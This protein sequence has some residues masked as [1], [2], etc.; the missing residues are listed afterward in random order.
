MMTTLKV[1]PFFSFTIF[2]HFFQYFFGYSSFFCSFPFVVAMY[3]NVFIYILFACT[4]DQSKENIQNI[5]VRHEEI[6]H[7]IFLPRR[8][9]YMLISI[10]T[11][12]KN[13]ETEETGAP[14][15]IIFLVG[16]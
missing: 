14:S 11:K 5:N 1:S 15:L 9:P 13:V 12:D 6:M 7:T 4:G 2:H 3:N 10:S 8:S 16:F